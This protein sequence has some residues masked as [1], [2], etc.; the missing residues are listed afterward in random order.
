MEKLLVDAC[1]SYLATDE[2]LFR[3]LDEVPM[4]IDN[5]DELAARRAKA[6]WPQIPVILL[7]AT[8]GRPE[9]STAQVITTQEQVAAAAN[10]KHIIVPDSG[11]YLHVDKPGL[12][13]KCIRDLTSI[14]H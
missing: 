5:L 9:D 8:K 6:V 2:Q 7:T 11:Q 12:V 1:Q 13:L 4:I 14:G 3:Y 10:G